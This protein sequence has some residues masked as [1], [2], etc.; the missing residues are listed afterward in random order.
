[1]LNIQLICIG[2]LKESYWREACAEY[3]KRLSAFCRFSIVELAES[4]L[5]DSPS[6]AQ[7]EA[8]LKDEGEKILSVVGNAPFFALCIEGK[9]LSSEQLSERIG[10]M[11]VNGASRLCFVIGSSFGL[12][13]PLKQ[14]A[15]FRLSMSPMTFP[16]QLARVM[17]CEQT[18]RAFQILN[19]G[20]YHK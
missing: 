5:S 2:K 9:T 15:A 1:M 19:N 10:L 4:R 6:P 7:I 13:A 12:S 17:L 14:A 20:K 16:H 11:A 3:A 18:Y 8:A